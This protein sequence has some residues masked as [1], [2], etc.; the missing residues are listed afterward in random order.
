MCFYFLCGNKI[1]F[2]GFSF[3]IR[4]LNFMYFLEGGEVIFLV[5]SRS[6]VVSFDYRFIV[7]WFF[8]MVFLNKNFEYSI[9]VFF[10]CTLNSRGI[11]SWF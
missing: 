8:Y 6:Y 4:E 3:F 2:F 9:F 7:V 10:I 1:F 11:R 5:F